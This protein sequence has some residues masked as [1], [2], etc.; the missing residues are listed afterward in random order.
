MAARPVERRVLPKPPQ[1]L[2]CPGLIAPISVDAPNPARRRFLQIAGTGLVA[3]PV[4]AL[5]PQDR[6]GYAV[7]G[8]GT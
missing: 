7:V 1:A 8:L 6:V 5:P 2:P 4:A 3:A